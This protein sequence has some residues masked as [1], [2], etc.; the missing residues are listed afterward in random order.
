MRYIP[1][2]Q[3]TATMILFQINTY[4]QKE[5]GIMVD[6]SDRIFTCEGSVMLPSDSDNNLELSTNKDIVSLVETYNI[7]RFGQS[8]RFV[9][10]FTQSNC[11]KVIESKEQS[12]I[13]EI[14]KK[15]KEPDNVLYCIYNNEKVLTN[16]QIGAICR[17]PYTIPYSLYYSNKSKF[18]ENEDYYMIKD[19]TEI[20][21]LYKQNQVSSIK[22]RKA[23]SL[24][25]FTIKGIRKIIEYSRNAELTI[26]LSDFLAKEG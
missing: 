4:L 22:Q 17:L 7:L 1:N 26:G 13:V 9:V 23:T 15:T 16:K 25:L 24:F 11:Q 3:D 14:D 2:N 5:K 21:K 10:A 18:F 12:T 20:I 19:F 6:E 8:N